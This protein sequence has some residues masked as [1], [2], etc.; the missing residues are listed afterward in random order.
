[1]IHCGD[2]T[3]IGKK[4]ELMKV[5]EWFGSLPHKTKIGIAGNHDTGLD[6]KQ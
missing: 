3:N 6:I 1:M 2:M 4:E 5:N